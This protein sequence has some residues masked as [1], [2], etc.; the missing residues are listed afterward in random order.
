MDRIYATMITI[1]VLHG[2]EPFPTKRTEE[3]SLYVYEM[4]ILTHNQWSQ[5]VA[6]VDEKL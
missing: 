3:R 5:N 1:A 6:P 4:C 2:S